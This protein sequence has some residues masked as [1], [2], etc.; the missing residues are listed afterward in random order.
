MTQHTPTPWRECGKDRGGCIC[1]TVWATEH[2]I[3]VAVALSCEDTDYT[4][5]DGATPETAQANAEHI[6]KACNNY[7]AMLEALQHITQ[8]VDSLDR[9]LVG[10]RPHPNDVSW[11]KQIVHD[12]QSK[13]RA[14]LATIDKGE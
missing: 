10:R 13:A 8:K 9:R 5:G 4:G 11:A 6:V 1:R 12:I 7:P 2:D 14:V 3:P